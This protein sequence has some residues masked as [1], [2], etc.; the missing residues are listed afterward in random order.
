MIKER[1]VLTVSIA[2]YN[3][4][5]FIETTL[6]SLIC[7]NIDKLE[8]IIQNDGSQDNTADIV[9][10]YVNKYPNT[11]ILNNK[12]NGGYGSTIN[13][14]IKVANGKYFKQLDGDDWFDTCNLDEFIDILESND[15]DCFITPYTCCYEN[16]KEKNTMYKSKLNTGVYSIEE[17]MKKSGDIFKMHLLTFRLDLLKEIDFKMLEHCFYTDQEYIMYPLTS[18]K[19]IYITNL[20]I[21]NYRMGNEGQSVSKQGL[22][23]HYKDHLRVVNQLLKWSSAIDECQKYTKKRLVHH[24]RVLVAQQYIIYLTIPSSKTVKEELMEY[25]KMLKNEYERFYRIPIFHYKMLIYKLRINKFES[26]NK[27]AKKFQ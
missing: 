12:E 7:R 2:A 19:K 16:N 20:N 3:V 5:K 6:E 14:S 22:I 15:A 10:K 26:Y 1:K 8:V 18:I 11:F 21:Y 13:E 25:D 4:E 17:V 9:A 27:Y 23:K 24:L